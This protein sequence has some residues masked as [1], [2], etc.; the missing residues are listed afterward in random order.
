MKKKPYAMILSVICMTALLFFFIMAMN[1][2]GSANDTEQAEILEQ[3]LTRS[4]TACYALE[5][6]YPPNI[7]YLTEHYGLT[8]ETDEYFIDYQYIGSN[9][10]PDVTIIKK[11]AKLWY[12]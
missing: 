2:I 3:A 1:R 12:D 8:Y 11:D 4:I 7:A 10:R 5:G 9:L 6:A